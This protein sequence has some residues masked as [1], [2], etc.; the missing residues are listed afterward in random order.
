MDDPDYQKLVIY[1]N[2][3]QQFNN[4]DVIIGSPKLW[5]NANQDMIANYDSVDPNDPNRISI[6]RN[7]L[8]R[9]HL[10]D[11]IIKEY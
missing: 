1:E 9:K 8:N 4:Q 11:M 5:I 6:R 7:R 10:L 3:A 2:I